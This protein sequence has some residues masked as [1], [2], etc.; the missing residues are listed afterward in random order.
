MDD[1]TKY[2]IE[3]YK[4]YIHDCYK[5]FKKGYKISK[6]EK[7]GADLFKNYLLLQLTLSKSRLKGGEN[8]DRSKK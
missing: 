2:L 3:V 8:D 7:Y 6:E 4:L 1:Y 5:E